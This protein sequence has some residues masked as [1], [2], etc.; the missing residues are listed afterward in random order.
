MF[1]YDSSV[2]RRTMVAVSLIIGA[3]AGVLAIVT[4]FGIETRRQAEQFL[5]D[6]ERLE[7][8]R[9]TFSDVEILAHKYGGKIYPG[10]QEC[11]P[12]K[13][14]FHFEFEN[15]WLHKIGLAPRT[16]LFAEVTVSAGRVASRTTSFELGTGPAFYSVDVLEWPK[17]PTDEHYRVSLQRSGNIRWRAHIRLTPEATPEQRDRAY[18]FNLDCL[19]RFF[20]CTDSADLL[21]SVWQDGS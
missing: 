15:Y 12:E 10:D 19:S 5:R 3:L 7:I 21:P 18:R 8:G 16:R 1:H 14:R 11:S 9:S 2:K 20:G 4:P 17:Q 13:C 6:A